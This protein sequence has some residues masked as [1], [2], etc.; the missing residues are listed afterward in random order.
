MIHLY[1]SS[2]NSIHGL[3][4]T[5][6]VWPLFCSSTRLCREKVTLPFLLEEQLRFI[7]IIEAERVLAPFSESGGVWAF[8]SI[9]RS[10]RA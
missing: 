1:L 6:I 10:G 3:A 8:R 4:N 7:K 5:V 9:S 2:L